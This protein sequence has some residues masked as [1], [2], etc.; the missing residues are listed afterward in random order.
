MKN[1]FRFK[2]LPVLLGLFLIL[3]FSYFGLRESY[4]RQD[5]W[6][7]LGQV[8]SVG[9]FH[10]LSSMSPMR[11]LTGELRPLGTIA[12]NLLHYLFP[13][14]VW[15]FVVFGVVFHWVN[16]ALVYLLVKRLTKNF[17]MA[18]VAS[19]FFAS[20]F[21]AS[22]SITW[23]AAVTTIL[24][25]T[26][27]FLL[28]LICFIDYGERKNR[29]L[30]LFSY[31]FLYVS[32][33]FKESALFG[34]L[35]VP[36]MVILFYKKELMRK[37]FVLFFAG[38]ALFL[39]T[40]LAVRSIGLSGQEGKV[41]GFATSG[42][43]LIPKLLTHT[44]TY[45]LTSFSQLFIPRQIMFHL[46]AL[47]QT[48]QYAFVSNSL[49][50]SSLLENVT[51]DILSILFTCVFLV[52]CFIIF[53]RKIVSR[54]VIL[55]SVIISLFSF[56]PYVLINKGTSYLDSRYYYIGEIGASIIAAMFVEAALSLLKK[57]NPVIRLAFCACVYLFFAIYIYKQI[58][59]IRRD[60][61]ALKREAS[62]QESLLKSFVAIAPDL[63]SKPVIYITG[64]HTYYGVDNLYV[65]LQAGP[66]YIF[67][68][69]YHNSHSVPKPL[70]SQGFLLDVRFED[71]KEVNGEGFGY[72]TRFDSLH[73]AY[74]HNVFNPGQLHAFYYDSDTY[75]VTDVTEETIKK[76][77]TS[78]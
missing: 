78:D 19:V 49:M 21:N 67:M 4:F 17:R 9:P 27:F 29:N 1:I 15:P 77:Q 54:R 6:A 38:P 24:P 73:A 23:F 61:Q 56:F 75:K 62:V 28:F 40:L 14:Q 33:L 3:F 7:S 46:S 32:I 22:Q 60:I 74:E 66:A 36:I 43:Q 47:Y 39:G 37:Q 18:V 13:F 45:P 63:G 16:S 58:I 8:L 35:L 65:P 10:F 25:C 68:V 30:I 55:F 57:Y 44:L 76:L 64:N 11:L 2:E 53:A 41:T 51:S 31:V 70:L 26:T 52:L 42:G 48:S 59:F 12:N 50:Q 34:L 69:M 5:E 20:V 72:Y 71:Y